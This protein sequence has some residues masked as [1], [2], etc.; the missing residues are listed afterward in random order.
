MQATHT[1]VAVAN[2]SVAALAAKAAPGRWLLQQ[3]SILLP[4]ACCYRVDSNGAYSDLGPRRM[5]AFLEL[6]RPVSGRCRGG[7]S[8]RSMN[9]PDRSGRMQLSETQAAEGKLRGGIASGQSRR[10]K[11][12]LYSDRRPA[13]RADGAPQR[14]GTSGSEPRPPRPSAASEKQL[15]AR[16]ELAQFRTVRCP[17]HRPLTQQ[18]LRLATHVTS[19]KQNLDAQLDCQIHARHPE[20]TST[21]C[22]LAQQGSV[23]RPDQAPS[24]CVLRAK[25]RGRYAVPGEARACRVNA[26]AV[27]AKRW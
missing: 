19:A 2:L 9:G 26:R 3:S 27:S 14:S 18:P 5:T 17:A 15:A 4:S 21:L 8:A 22:L 16:G 23:Q 20:S 1:G 6:Q 12:S 11:A 13:Y 25:H 24:A 10:A 7:I